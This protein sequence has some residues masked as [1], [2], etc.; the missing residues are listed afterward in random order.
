MKRSSS[1]Q[2]R[3]GTSPS[4]PPYLYAETTIERFRGLVRELFLSADQTMAKDYLRCLVERIVVRDTE[5]EI[6]GKTQRTVALLATSPELICLALLSLR[7]KFLLPQVFGSAFGAVCEPVRS[8]LGGTGSLGS[9]RPESANACE[10]RW[11]GDATGDTLSRSHC[12]ATNAGADC[13]RPVRV[14]HGVPLAGRRDKTPSLVRCLKA[15]CP[16]GVQ[17]LRARGRA[18]PPARWRSSHGRGA[19]PGHQPQDALRDA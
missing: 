19:A 6:H 2:R 7:N 11:L 3:E 8:A 5:L 15:L 18:V 17:G 14:P 13:R 4:F 12:P 10:S 16:H 1:V 9:Q